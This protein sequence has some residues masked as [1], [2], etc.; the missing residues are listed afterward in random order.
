[1]LADSIQARLQS[2]L[3]TPDVHPQDTS[4][5]VMI[6]FIQLQ[7]PRWRDSNGRPAATGEDALTS[8][9]CVY[10]NG[11]AKDTALDSIQFAPQYPTEKHDKRRKPDVTILPR[12][13]Q[14]ILVEG[15]VHT[16]YEP[17]LLI[18]CKVLPTPKGSKRDEREYVISG[19]SSTGGI[20]RFK[21]GHH[22]AEH[23]LAV[24]IAYVQSETFS[25]WMESISKWITDLA[26]A[27]QPTWTTGDLL[28]R[29]KTDKKQGI[30]I[31]HSSHTREN[32]LPKIELRHLWLKMN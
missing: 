32:D 28:R 7:L 14:G 18:E 4:R 20:Q 15:R 26:E 30:A 13:L 12:E 1:M 6:E 29:K 25:F 27:G 8:H 2:G 5:K 9:L 10:L 21:A 3:L 16:I 17:V 11:A 19:S 24:M 31:L 23:K 22:G